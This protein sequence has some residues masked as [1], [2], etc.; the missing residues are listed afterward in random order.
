MQLQL[1]H[2]LAG[3]LLNLFQCITGEIYKVKFIIYKVKITDNL[4]MQEFNSLFTSTMD[5][6]MQGLSLYLILGI[7]FVFHILS[8]K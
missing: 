4:M 3:K 1:W 8:L 7:S 6:I 5:G 2:L